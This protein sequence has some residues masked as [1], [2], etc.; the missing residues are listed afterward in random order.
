MMTRSPTRRGSLKLYNSS[1]RIRVFHLPDLFSTKSMRRIRDSSMLA[2]TRRCLLSN[3]IMA[4][5]R[6]GATTS[7]EKIQPRMD[8]NG[9]PEALAPAT[10]LD[11]ET[12]GARLAVAA[13]LPEALVG[14]HQCD[15]QTG[16]RLHATGQNAVHQ[17]EGTVGTD[18]SQAPT[19]AG[20]LVMNLYGDAVAP[21]L[22]G[23][24]LLPGAT[25]E[26]REAVKECHKFA[27][28]DPEPAGGAGTAIE[29]QTAVRDWEAP[30]EGLGVEIEGLGVE[31]EG[32]GV[33]IEVPGVAIGDL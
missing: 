8:A 31:T 4:Q 9:N 17:Q 26:G 28:E 14:A 16:I 2:S 20:H 30:I 6:L 27:T 33:A 19:V 7:T 3:S 21:T 29:D 24:A 25:V 12:G 10:G 15:D 22:P 23:G 13:P 11:L 32:L 18:A 1:K 5:T